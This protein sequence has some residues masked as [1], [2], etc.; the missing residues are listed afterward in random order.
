MGAVVSR[1][2]PL[3]QRYALFFMSSLLWAF[4]RRAEVHSSALRTRQKQGQ[5]RLDLLP[6]D[7]IHEVIHL[8][9]QRLFADDLHTVDTS[10]FNITH[11]YC[12]L[13]DLYKDPDYAP[14]Q[15]PMPGIQ[16]GKPL[17]SSPGLEAL[18]YTA[19]L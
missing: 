15:C 1:R 8:L 9:S 14:W 5:G 10:V 16:T 4:G 6:H 7:I 3:S 2:C 18:Q 17:V 12:L 11:E 19:T 13:D